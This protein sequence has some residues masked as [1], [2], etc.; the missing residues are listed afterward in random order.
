VGPQ[1]VFGVLPGVTI[2]RIWKSLHPIRSD[3]GTSRRP[4]AA[5]TQT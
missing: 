3:D 4:G 2:L 5:P 1:A